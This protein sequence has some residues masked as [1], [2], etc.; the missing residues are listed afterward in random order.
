MQLKRSYFRRLKFKIV[1]YAYQFYYAT[2]LLIYNTRCQYQSTPI[3]MNTLKMNG[4]VTK[5]LY[6]DINQTKLASIKNLYENRNN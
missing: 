5:N 4:K 3:S 2:C 6:M 1:F